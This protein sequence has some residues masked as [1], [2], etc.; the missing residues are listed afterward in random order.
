MPF[1]QGNCQG[2]KRDLALIQ[3]EGA[4]PTE[5]RSLKLS[6]ESPSPGQRVHSVG[7][8]GASGALWVYTPGSV[9]QVYH[10]KFERRLKTAKTCLRL[11]PKSWKP[12]RA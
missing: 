11:T 1:R 7:N 2:F 12:P 9:R 6:K 4:I 8:P 3:L 5:A 10:H